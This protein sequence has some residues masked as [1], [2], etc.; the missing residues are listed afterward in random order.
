MK[1]ACIQVKPRR[2]GCQTQ[3][4]DVST[5]QFQTE[6]YSSCEVQVGFMGQMEFPHSTKKSLEWSMLEDFEDFGPLSA[7]P[8]FTW[9]INMY[10]SFPLKCTHF[11]F[12]EKNIFWPCF[13]QDVHWVVSTLIVRKQVETIPKILGD[14]SQEEADWD[15]TQKGSVLYPALTHATP[16]TAEIFCASMSCSGGLITLSPIRLPGVLQ[17]LMS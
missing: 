4:T 5:S 12:Q 16:G 13:P 9:V 2:K 1:P 8:H 3:K 6:S 11:T 10:I 15:G 17:G 14:H 7:L